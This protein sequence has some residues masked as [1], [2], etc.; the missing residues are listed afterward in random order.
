MIADG[1]YQQ[2]KI[3]WTH[4]KHSTWIKKTYKKEII[5]VHLNMANIEETVNTADE[6]EEREAAYSDLDVK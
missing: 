2:K 6:H 1:Y 3:T 5:L 4:F